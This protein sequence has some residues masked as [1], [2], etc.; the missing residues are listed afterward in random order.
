MPE[1]TGPSPRRGP[2]R[3]GAAAAAGLLGAALYLNTAGNDFVFDDLDVVARNPAARDPSELRTIAMS[4]YWAGARPEGNLYRPL[5]IWSFAL[6]HA[7]TG[8]GPAGYHVTNALLHGGVSAL[9]SLLAAALGIGTGGALVTGLLFAAHPVH[10]EAVAPVV[11]RSEILA[12]LGALG[13]WLLHLAAAGPLRP[14]GPAPAAGARRLRAAAS[15]AL[16]A[17]ALL[18]KEHA[19]VLPALALAADASLGGRARLRRTLPSLL[20][21]AAVLGT[22]LAVRAAVVGGASG[23][24]A[25]GVF[26]G[27]GAAE[28]I[29][30][31]VGVLGRYLVLTVVPWRL[32][33]DY[34]FHQIPLVASPSDPLVL[35]SAAAHLLLAGAGIAL[36]AR[37]RI[38]GVALLVYLGALFP[39]SNLAFS[40]GTVM[41]ERL[42]YLPSVGACLLPAALAADFPRLLRRRGARRAAAAVLGAVIVLFGARVVVRNADW[43]DALTLFTATAAASPRSAKAH[44]NLGVALDERGDLAGALESYGRAAEIKPDMVEARRNLGL[45]LLRAGRPAEA[46]VHLAAAAGLDPSIPDLFSDLGIALH[47]TGRAE[48]AAAAFRREIALRPEGARARYNLGS[49]LLEAGR[50]EEA[51]G[52]LRSAAALAPQDPDAP[53]AMGLAL[54]ELGRHAEAAEALSR[55]LGL[56]PSRTDLLVPLAR[57]ARAAGRADLELRAVERARSAGIRLSDEPPR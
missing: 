53:A 29:L 32:S 21:L 5:T 43:R 35:A 25:A 18:S 33:A 41:A 48:E 22:W 42:L 4:H 38:S 49:L 12:A 6:N 15:A 52:E 9:A 2:G 7:V 24:A 10:V 11:G 13:A 45:A 23:E 27:V 50:P 34:S 16:F 47:Q 20:L 8:P 37:R 40:I 46:A 19:A 14:E 56:D 57:A 3:L 31:A 17:A 26:D 51:L 28:R 1:L 54:A 55:A 30:T 39:V 36:A 44:Y